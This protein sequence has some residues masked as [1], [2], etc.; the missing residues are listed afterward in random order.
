MSFSLLY[1]KKKIAIN[2]FFSGVSKTFTSTLV[3][4]VNF[5]WINP[6][7]LGTW[8]SITVF[9]AYSLIL[10][11]GLT[12]GLNR[13]L[14]YYLGKDDQE[15]AL[16]RVSA[17][18]YYISRLSILLIAL[19]IV[20]LVPLY[21]YGNIS[22]RLFFMISSAISIASLNIVT[23]Y[24]G[25]TFRSSSSFS[26]LANIQWVSIVPLLLSIPLV[27]FL[28]I[29]GY[30][31]YNIFSLVF[32]F[33]AMNHYKPFKIKYKPNFNILKDLIKVG[34]PYYS[35]SQ[36]SLLT[37]SISRLFLV[38]FGNPYILGLFAP[39]YSI[40]VAMSS[41]PSYINRYL[42]PRMVY[43]YGKSNDIYAIYKNSI[44]IIVKL[45][46]TMLIIAVLISFFIPFLFEML[47]PKY[48]EGASSAIIL[49]FYGVLNALVSVLQNTFY[50]LKAIKRY[51]FSVIF[52]FVYYIISILIVYIV[53]QNLLLAASLGMLFGELFSLVTFIIYLR[54]HVKEFA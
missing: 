46:I 37:Q 33:F 51:L 52:K 34:A 11:F 15:S 40:F 30:I 43:N 8:Q 32:L 10:T 4:I 41:L 22:L 36:L 35:I 21:I 16:V 42:F 47:F 50:A 49:I 27:Y 53:T 20:I 31:L 12:S 1:K 45:G 3:N 18:G 29:I 24:L 39:G 26:K 6:E 7:D 9:T 44:T 5:R 48:M 17:S 23:N 14:P 2:Y 54:Y 38:F 13:E 25:A 19:S 28:N